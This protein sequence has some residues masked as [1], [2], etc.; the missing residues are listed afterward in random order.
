MNNLSHTKL[1]HYIRADLLQE[2]QKDDRA[3]PLIPQRA[4]DMFIRRHNCPEDMDH[5]SLSR[6]RWARRKTGQLDW[7]QAKIDDKWGFYVFARSHGFN[8]PRIMFCSSTGPSSLE[9]FD[10]P[11]LSGFVIKPRFGGLS[12]GIFVMES[13]FDSRE[14]FTNMIMTKDDVVRAMTDEVKRDSRSATFHVEEIMEDGSGDGVPVD[15]KFFIANGSVISA[16]LVFSR[17]RPLNCVAIV[18]E[19]FNR[20]DEHGCFSL[21]LPIRYKK[22]KR[23][24]GN[25]TVPFHGKLFSYQKKCSEFRR[26]REWH[27]L[28]RVAKRFSS[29]IGI[30]ARVDLFLHKGRVF[31]GEVEFVPTKGKFHCQSRLNDEGCVD[32]CIHGRVWKENGVKFDS[33]EGGPI[34]QE[35]ESLKDWEQHTHEQQCEK[36]LALK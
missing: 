10:P 32:P 22:V 23:S 17:G 21:E 5:L 19:N 30:W 8:V 27:E 14:K 9:K 4:E 15:Y 35:P 24:N 18:D 29:M 26:P 33:I 25:C 34:T 2:R 28:V 16:V 31:L 11:P 12:R 6:Q 36:V 13:G 3:L 7:S 1:N 20:M